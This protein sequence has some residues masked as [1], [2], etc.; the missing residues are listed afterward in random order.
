MLSNANVRFD[1]VTLGGEAFTIAVPE[2]PNRCWLTSLTVALGPMAR[3]EARRALSGPALWATLVLSRLLEGFTRLTRVDDAVWPEHRLLTTSLYS[4]RLPVL[5]DR[6]DDLTRLYPGKAIV[7]RSLTEPQPGTVW[8][9]RV[10]WRIDDLAR[11]WAPRTDTRNDLKLLAK[12]G[13]TPKA[14]GAAIDEARLARCRDLYRQL[15]LGVYSVFNPDYTAAGLRRLL[16]EGLELHTLE[17]GQGEIVAFCALYADGET[18]TLPMLGYDLTRPQSDGLYR[19]IQVH[20]AG[21]AAGRGLKLN[22]S[23]GAPHFKRNRGAT[24]W[25][26]YLLIVDHHLPVWRRTGYRLTGRILRAL[27][28]QLKRA[29]GA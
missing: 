11:D 8:P 9:F 13:L 25:M 2:P 24:P 15:Y 22:L 18:V 16:A 17:D 27:E 6:I 23:A 26:E 14:Y 10:V 7:I 5:L 29:A 28:P 19:A 1:S 21:L 20:M 4:G 3:Q 12:S